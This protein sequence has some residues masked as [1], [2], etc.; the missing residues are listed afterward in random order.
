MS[1]LWKEAYEICEFLGGSKD[2]NKIYMKLAN[3]KKIITIDEISDKFNLLKIDDHS[4][5]EITN[6]FRKHNISQ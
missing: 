6:K 5:E 3:E 4:V 2:I 1:D